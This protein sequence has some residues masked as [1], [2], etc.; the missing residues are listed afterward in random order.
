[1]VFRPSLPSSRATALVVLCALP[2]VVAG[3]CG[4]GQGSGSVPQP[5]ANGSTTGQPVAVPTAQESA[6]E[7]LAR[8][9]ELAGSEDCDTVNELNVV[10]RT[11]LDNPRRCEYLRRLADYEPVGSSFYSMSAATVDF[12]Q[13]DRVIVASLVVDE[14]GLYKILHLD[15]FLG[16]TAADT[17]FAHEFDLVAERGVDAL[18]AGDCSRFR[19]LAYRGLGP[20][21]LPKRDLCQYVKNNPLGPVLERFPTSQVRRLG[22]NASYAFHSLETPVAAF[23]IVTARQLE[24]RSSSATS[25]SGSGDKPGELVEYAF[26]DVVAVERR[27][28]PEATGPLP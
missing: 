9:V 22:G 19:V 27:D 8:V 2:L 7:T 25:E 28:P 3:G 10:A 23:V 20:G 26:L 11:G 12:A 13:D 15:P 24:R 1:M 6:G 5:E 14:D 21:A 18:K 4:G 16:E 17:S